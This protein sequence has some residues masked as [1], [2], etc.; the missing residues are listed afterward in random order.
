MMAAIMG[1]CGGC[2]SP[3]EQVLAPTSARIFAGACTY[4][5]LTVFLAL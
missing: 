1:A 3:L 2:S 5:D 4:I